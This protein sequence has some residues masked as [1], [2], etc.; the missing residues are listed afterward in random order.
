MAKRIGL[1]ALAIT[2]HETFAGYDAAD[3]RERRRPGGDRCLVAMVEVIGRRS[4]RHVDRD[5]L[6]LDLPRHDDGPV[7]L[8][9]DLDLGDR[10]EHGPTV[11]RSG[12]A[13]PART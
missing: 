2:D 4:R 1:D 6:A 7:R 9:V 12:D 3:P 11:R 13:E 10:A 8:G 5:R